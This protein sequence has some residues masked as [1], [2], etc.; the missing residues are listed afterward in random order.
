M[1]AL[2][3]APGCDTVTG[4]RSRDI[5][6]VIYASVYSL[7]LHFDLESWRAFIELLT[8]HIAL[9]IALIYWWDYLR[10]KSFHSYL[11][12]RPTKNFSE[13]EREANIARNRALLEQLELKQAVDSLGFSAKAPPKTKAKPVQP[14]KKV[15]KEAEAPRRQSARLR[16]S[17]AIDPDESPSKKRK[18]EVG[19]ETL[20]IHPSYEKCRQR[21]RNDLPR[22]LK[23][24]LSFRSANDFPNGHAITTWILS[25]SWMKTLQRSRLCPMFY[26]I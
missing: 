4:Q 25:L 20:S 14:A 9:Q 15:K 18:R 24:E 13:R 5:R 19:A 2:N 10:S 7:C 12:H 3:N 11:S 21:N 26:K 8:H 22:K 1:E 23:T 16:S 6:L 17:A